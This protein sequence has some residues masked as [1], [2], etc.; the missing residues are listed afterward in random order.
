[1][2]ENGSS[3]GD[4][5]TGDDL[6]TP[7][8][9]ASPETAEFWAATS[10]DRLLLRHCTDCDAT[11]HP[12]RRICPECHGDATEW[13]EASGEGTIYTFSVMRQNFGPFGEAVPYVLAYVELDEGPRILT[14]VVGV[15]V[16]EVEIGQRVTIAFDDTGE[17]PKLP[18]FTPA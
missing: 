17:G 3:A 8:P 10:E 7:T 6:P 12:P 2:S 13:I 4:S 15:D 5:P 9:E 18:R 1:M 16:D 14:N 11:F